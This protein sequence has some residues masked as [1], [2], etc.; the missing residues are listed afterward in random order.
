MQTSHFT[1][2]VRQ[3]YDVT[4][5]IMTHHHHRKSVRNFLLNPR[6]RQSASPTGQTTNKI[7]AAALRPL[8]TGRINTSPHYTVQTCL[9]MAAFTES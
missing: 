6:K 3:R 9:T 8:N 2:F 4:I 5:D 7:T 1:T